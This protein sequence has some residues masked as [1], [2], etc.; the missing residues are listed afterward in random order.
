MGVITITFPQYTVGDH[1]IDAIIKIKGEPDLD[2]ESWAA[3]AKNLTILEFGELETGVDINDSLMTYNDMKL[4]IADIDG[5]LENYIFLDP[6]D[7]AMI[8]PE[9]SLTLELDSTVIFFGHLLTELSQYDEIEKILEINFVA[10]I[11]RLHEIPIV[12]DDGNYVDYFSYGTGHYLNIYLFLEAIF[13]EATVF[14]TAVIGSFEIDWTFNTSANSGAVDDVLIWT[15]RIYRNGSVQSNS[16]ADVVKNLMRCWGCIVAMDGGGIV[17]IQP[18]FYR[19]TTGAQTPTAILNKKRIYE[20]DET[21]YYKSTA[22]DSGGSHSLGNYH[23]FDDKRIE[24]IQ[25]F[26]FRNASPSGTPFY[27]KEP[28]PS[29]ARNPVTDA[30]V[31]EL[32]TGL[33]STDIETRL[34]HNRLS[35]FGNLRTV[36][37]TFPGLDYTLFKL[38]LVDSVYYRPVNIK[39]NFN[40]GTSVVRAIQKTW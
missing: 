21:T 31:P 23:A 11:A 17:R 40:D 14:D 15:E 26:W 2:S 22:N 38:F 1:T 24:S 25:D 9:I 13:S 32:T 10:S 33:E 3:D 35:N 6:L 34:W 29:T 36:E 7:R 20:Y 8:N 4:K 16:L 37:F 12:D 5:E 18:F 27:I 39:R 28:D 19:T 30:D